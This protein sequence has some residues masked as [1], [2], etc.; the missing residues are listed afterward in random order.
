MP[1]PCYRVRDWDRYFENNRTREYKQLAWLPVPNKH[2][3]DGYTELLD[4]PNGTAHYG[5]WMLIAQVAS[6]CEMRGTLL[7]DGGRPYDAATLARKTR[8]SRQVIEEALPRLVAIG[9]LEIID[10]ES[11]QLTQ[12]T[13]ATA[14]IPQATADSSQA[15][16]ARVCARARL[17]TNETNET[18]RNESTDEN[19]TEANERTRNGTP[20]SDGHLADSK[21]PPSRFFKDGGMGTKAK[22]DHRNGDTDQE[23]EQLCEKVLGRD[24]MVHCRSRWFKRAR[25]NPDKL[26]RVLGEMAANEREGGRITNRGGYAEDLWKRFS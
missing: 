22:A 24:E 1:T 8:G 6:K 2:D 26:R 19:R 20:V 10:L 3:G 25:D 17:R 4:H 12:N 18:K 21:R 14:A 5:A 23:L 15:E 13:Q 9:W 16:P 11:E 7:R